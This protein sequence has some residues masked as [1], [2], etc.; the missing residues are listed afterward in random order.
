MLRNLS[1]SYDRYLD[2]EAMT[3]MLHR[4]LCHSTQ[5]MQHVDVNIGSLSEESIESG[6]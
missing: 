6:R 4:I 2:I 1:N 5:F 3:Q